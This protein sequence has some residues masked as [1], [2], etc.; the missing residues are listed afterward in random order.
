MPEIQLPTAAKQDEI[1][2]EVSNVFYDLDDIKY[3][4]PAEEATGDYK[5]ILE[6]QG[7]GEL[8]SLFLY[9]KLDTIPTKLRITIDGNVIYEKSKTVSHIVT[10]YMHTFQVGTSSLNLYSIFRQSTTDSGNIGVFDPRNQP[11][12]GILL[13][14]KVITF[15][16]SLK[17]E[18]SNI[19]ASTTTPTNYVSYRLT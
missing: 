15:S 10:S 9:R 11:T 7:S 18:A 2:K 19:K 4:T 14:T 13:T 6:V 17:I 16:E 12:L 5:T 1:L 8:L 3:V